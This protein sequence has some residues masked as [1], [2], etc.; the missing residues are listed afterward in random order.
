[1]QP[2]ATTDP[3]NH[4]E[5]SS[6]F[7]QETYDSQPSP[8][9]PPEVDL[10]DPNDAH[11]TESEESVEES[12][13]VMIQPVDT[14]HVSEAPEVATS[15]IRF[16]VTASNV[17]SSIPPNRVAGSIADIA[18][19]A[20]G[21]DI[22]VGGV[23]VRDQSSS[24]ILSLFLPRSARYDA[25]DNSGPTRTIDVELL[26][27]VPK[28]SSRRVRKQMVDWVKSGSWRKQLEGSHMSNVQL[29]VA[30][31]S[32]PDR[33]NA[34]AT[35][36]TTGGINRKRPEQNDKSPGK[37]K[38]TKRKHESEASGMS[39]GGALGIATAAIVVLAVI[40]LFA[41][42]TVRA[43]RHRDE[44]IEIRTVRTEALT[45]D[46]DCTGMEASE[47]NYSVPSMRYS[48]A[49][50]SNYLENNVD[51]EF[52]H[53]VDARPSDATSILTSSTAGVLR[54]S[55]DVSAFG[56]DVASNHYSVEYDGARSL[57]E[58]DVD[59]LPTK[60]RFADRLRNDY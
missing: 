59:P 15:T 19:E 42:W 46:D 31:T 13:E 53:Y 60:P 14:P 6:T 18:T 45:Q 43:R 44:P 37:G 11:N 29:V 49:R 33:D 40:S 32:P 7:F 20:I 34:P 21:V 50:E 10:R 36:G 24:R 48:F 9:V 22:Q 56:D 8:S 28:G 39:L 2:K 23:K 1:M 41:V 54:D 35:G 30:D 27:D 52:A 25:S 51:T 57:Y 5:P 4:A 26:A 47:S 3:S 55:E 17:P 38:D 58:S 12:P 16:S